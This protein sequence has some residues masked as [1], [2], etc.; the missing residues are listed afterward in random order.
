MHTGE[1]SGE[2]RELNYAG[3]SSG[4]ESHSNGSLIIPKVIRDHEGYFLC[5]A[6]NGIGP[7]LSK[8]IKLT[9]HGNFYIEN[10]QATFLFQN[11]IF[12]F[13]ILKFIL[14]YYIVGPHVTVRNKQVS[15]RRG[16]R[17]TLR[18]EADGDQP[19]D[20][21]WRAK[22]NRIDPAY[23][24][25]YHLKN[26]PLSRGVVSELT[27]VQS[28]LSDRGEYSC[29]ASNAY[30]HDHAALHLQVQEPPNFPRNL[31]ITE[32]GSRSVTLSWTPN[33]HEPTTGNY[34]E[35]QPISNYI[36]QYKEA[37]GRY[38]CC[39]FFLLPFESFKLQIEIISRRLA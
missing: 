31:H 5:Q 26:S 35:S 6:S 27:I 20:V 8:L 37:Q 39:L 16:D 2:Y 34:R 9:V 22:G 25:R 18:C 17:V 1:Q 32:L 23:D 14:L 11:L 24:I 36:L 15:V 30:G 3:S 7:G 33:D 10:F 38:I 28:V 29:V 4:I 21:S 12:I 19:L 13:S